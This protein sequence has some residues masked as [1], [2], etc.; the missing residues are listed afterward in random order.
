[1]IFNM[2]C[3]GGTYCSSS[4]WMALLMK[5]LADTA[6]GG[7]RPWRSSRFS[8][9]SSCFLREFIVTTVKI[10]TGI[11][12]NVLKTHKSQ[13]PHRDSVSCDPYQKRAASSSNQPTSP[14]RGFR[15]LCQQRC[16]ELCSR[17]LISEGFSGA[18]FLKRNVSRGCDDY[19]FGIHSRRRRSLPQFTEFQWSSNIARRANGP[20]SRVHIAMGPYW[21][22]PLSIISPVIL[23]APCV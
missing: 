6:W 10:S 1:M 8:S 13:V 22:Q 4:M 3:R 11:G 15:R 12:E 9:S 20:L 23:P 14:G 16:A 21:A 18:R 19:I 2:R 5:V 7:V 17:C